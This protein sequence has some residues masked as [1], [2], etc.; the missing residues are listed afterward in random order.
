MTAKKHSEKKKPSQ[1]TREHES[2]SLQQQLQEKQDKLL[3]AYADLQNQQKRSEKE[4]IAK[5]DELK[6][7][8]LTELLDVYE[9]IQKAF[10]D[11]DPKTGLKLLLQNMEKF[12]E[13]EHVTYIEC[14]GKPFNPQL[15]HAISTTEK[16]DCG[17]DTIVEEIKKGYLLGEKLLRPSQV[18]VAKKKETPQ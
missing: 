7:K 16:N 8:Y 12:F 6:K 5:E 10:Q 2:T 11:T 14:T 13:H 1:D 9:I 18:V 3:R 15:H 4:W 17:D